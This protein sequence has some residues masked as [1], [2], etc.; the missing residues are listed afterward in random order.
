M[1]KT[2]KYIKRYG[3][4]IVEVKKINLCSTYCQ[5]RPGIDLEDMRIVNSPHKELAE[6]Y[7]KHGINWLE[8]NFKNTKYYGFQKFVLKSD[9]CIS[10]KKICLFDS[11]KKGYLRE[12]YEKDHIVVLNKSFI[13][14]RYGLK[15][16]FESSFEIFMGHHRAGALIALGR[17][18][19]EVIIAKD[20]QPM[21]YQC[22]GKLHNLYKDIK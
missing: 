6:L 13:S 20:N 7:Y 16:P 8:D 15:D 14:T 21:T 5:Y 1:S 17:R 11:L 4:K 3:L 18:E 9:P 12:G 19:V 22:Y 10:R 2:Y